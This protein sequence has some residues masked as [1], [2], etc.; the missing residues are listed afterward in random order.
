[1]LIE[2]KGRRRWRKE[3][4]RLKGGRKGIMMKAWRE[5]NGEEE[6]EWYEGRS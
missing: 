1:M 6:G 2:N 4:E 3:R 5:R